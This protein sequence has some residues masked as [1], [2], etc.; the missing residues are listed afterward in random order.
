MITK[1]VLSLL[2][3][4]DE[5]TFP[6]ADSNG[7]IIYPKIGPSECTDPEEM[8]AEELNKWDIENR[9]KLANNKPVA[10]WPLSEKGTSKI[11]I[12][13]EFVKTLQHLI[14]VRTN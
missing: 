9:D 5:N 10:S 1:T 12:Y 2:N 8:L 7:N 11:I 6:T 3:A 4:P 13:V 14:D